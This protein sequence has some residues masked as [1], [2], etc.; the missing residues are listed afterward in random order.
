MEACFQKLLSKGFAPNHITM[1][2]IMTAFRQAGRTSKV[3]EYF[4]LLSHFNLA[5][6]EVT[7]NILHTSYG[8]A[9]MFDKQA[10]IARWL[11]DMRERQG[12]ES[13]V[14]SNDGERTKRLWE[15]EGPSEVR[16]FFPPSTS[17][18]L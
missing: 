16:R 4:N 5:P 9:K 6:D 10:K 2:T 8:R 11:D 12:G 13:K 17:R 14:R 15:P 7:L 18:E 3:E 1:A